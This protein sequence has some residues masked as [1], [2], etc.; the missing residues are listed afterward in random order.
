MSNQNQNTNAV[1]ATSPSK[2][3]HMK[4]QSNINTARYNGLMAA[5]TNVGR[6]EAAQRLAALNRAVIKYGLVEQVMQP[7]KVAD[8]LDEFMPL[9]GCMAS[10]ASASLKRSINRWIAKIWQEDAPE[11][12]KVNANAPK[13]EFQPWDFAE[14]AETDNG[15]PDVNFTESSTPAEVED[16]YRLNRTVAHSI[17]NI[18]GVKEVQWLNG[19]FRSAIE[20]R[21][22]G[23][24]RQVREQ[25]MAPVYAPIHERLVNA[26]AHN[27]HRDSLWYTK[28]L[29]AHMA[30]PLTDLGYH[31]GE[32]H[33]I[34]AQYAEHMLEEIMVDGEPTTR[35]AVIVTQIAS[36][37]FHDWCE[38]VQEGSAGSADMNIWIAYAPERV[39]FAEQ[40]MSSLEMEEFLESEEQAAV[41]LT[42]REANKARFGVQRTGQ[43]APAQV[44]SMIDVPVRV[45]PSMAPRVITG[46]GA[47]GFSQH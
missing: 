12:E 23:T 44:Q 7:L 33:E 28:Q 32:I 9:H 21:G 35:L 5:N 43:A 10:I 20:L 38:R 40:L 24:V 47:A 41:E 13:L 16:D 31:E 34:K 46:R 1:N 8:S 39:A 18:R 22:D 42:R 25:V 17:A 6:L 19:T 2:E 4:A 11:A 15:Q 30:Y 45:I 27:Q 14:S 37:K 29:Y 26:M 3:N 36:R